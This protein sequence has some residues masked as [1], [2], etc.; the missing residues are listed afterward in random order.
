MTLMLLAGKVKS[1][2]KELFKVLPSVDN[3]LNLYS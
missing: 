3:N 1:I 2:R